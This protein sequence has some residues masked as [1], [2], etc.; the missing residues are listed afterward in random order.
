MSCVL[1]VMLDV[2]SHVQVCSS[3]VSPP[4]SSL[5]LSPAPTPITSPGVYTPV[6]NAGSESGKVKLEKWR[7]IARKLSLHNKL[8]TQWNELKMK[9]GFAT[10]E[11]FIGHLLCLEATRQ[12]SQDTQPQPSQAI[13]TMQLFDEDTDQEEDL[14]SS[15]ACHQQQ[16]IA[17]SPTAPD[18]NPAGRDEEVQ[19]AEE[20][21][22]TL[23]QPECSILT[24]D[25]SELEKGGTED[26]QPTVLEVETQP[27]PDQL[28]DG[29]S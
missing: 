19:V 18:G 27:V 7:Q 23:L 12:A 8:R 24:G 28:M 3:S 9:G 2:G 10:N 4:P 14:E 26:M 25:E 5:V 22:G 21:V 13:K 17:L 20:E 29:K 16:Y 6:K 1:T 15:E 11:E